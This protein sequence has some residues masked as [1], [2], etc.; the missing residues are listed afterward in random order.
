MPTVVTMPAVTMRAQPGSIAAVIG[1]IA[2][3]PTTDTAPDCAATDWLCHWIFSVSGK[4]WLAE[5]GYYVVLK[6]ARIV[7]IILGAILL[8]VVARRLLR[9]LTQRASSPRR[10]LRRPFRRTVAVEPDTASGLRAERRRQRAETLG[11]VL[12]TAVSVTIFSVATM[13]VL[14]ELGI[15]LAPLIASAGI[16]GVAL[17]FGAQNL[18]KDYFAGLFI[19]IEDQFGVGDNV[20]VGEISGVVEEVGLRITT[21]RDLQGVIWYIRNGEIVR[22]GNRSQG[23]AV[24]VV[25]VPVGFAGVE[26]ATE[27][28]RAAAAT[29]VDDP[30]WA[31]DLLDAPEVLGVEQVTI[32][33]AVVRTT[34]KTVPAARWR[35]ARELRR[36][37]T[38]ALESAGIAEHLR[39]YLRPRLPSEPTTQPGRAGSA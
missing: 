33:G 22:V 17:G 1:T 35:V 37:L 19:L 24:V 30:E 21:I 7:L 11:S 2:P 13:L 15:D 9:R 25:D 14:G 27:V 26:E 10:G 4:R 29:L 18:I 23:W 34:V 5:A 12:R 36:R 20:D 6:P 32:E 3:S 8:H 16:L 31:D 39:E 28:L 38:E